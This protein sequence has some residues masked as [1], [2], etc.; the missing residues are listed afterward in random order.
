[1]SLRHLVM[2]PG[3]GSAL[4]LAFVLSL[5]ADEGT[6]YT[7][8]EVVALLEQAGLRHEETLGLESRPESYLIIGRK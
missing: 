8:T 5:F 3:E 4:R 2:S 7:E 6:V 1:M